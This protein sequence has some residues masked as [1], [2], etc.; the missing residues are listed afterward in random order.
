MKSKNK[1]LGKRQLARR[2]QQ[3]GAILYPERQST[4]E[5]V[6]LFLVDYAGKL[7][8]YQS[9]DAIERWLNTMHKT[10]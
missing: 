10:I 9:L 2:C 1:R 8:G 4:N 6:R 5:G 3:V 7:M